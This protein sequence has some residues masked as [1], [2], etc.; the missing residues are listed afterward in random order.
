MIRKLGQV[1]IY[2]NDQ[3]AAIKFWMSW[4]EIAPTKSAE[5]S[6]VLQNKEL[7]AKLEPEVN[8]GTPSLLFYA[9]NL[10]QVYEDFKSKGITVGV[11]VNVP[12]GKVFNFADEEG[13]YFAI[14]EK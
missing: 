3:E 13:N 11:I 7:V 12:E 9:D 1:M 6:F 14:V 5:T 8:V 4:Y 2:V 10:E